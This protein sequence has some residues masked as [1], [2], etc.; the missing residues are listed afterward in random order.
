MRLALAAASGGG[1]PGTDLAAPPRVWGEATSRSW[2][3]ASI[4]RRRLAIFLVVDGL[5]ELSA[6]FSV[7]TLSCLVL[8][9]ELQ[10]FRRALFCSGPAQVEAYW[11][12]LLT[13]LD[14][15]NCV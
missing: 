5:C 13:L 14:L 3:A 6:L 15:L 2:K 1:S 9:L 8:G 7:F 12:F 4:A 10:G 11:A